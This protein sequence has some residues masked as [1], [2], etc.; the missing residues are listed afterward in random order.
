MITRSAPTALASRPRLRGVCGI[1]SGY[2]QAASLGLITP[3]VARDSRVCVYDRAGR[4]W[5]D[6]AASPPDGAQIATDLHRLLDR[7]RVPGP[8]VL[9]GQSFGGLYVRAY[10]ARYPDE[11]AGL[12]LV[13]STAAS[14]SPVIRKQASSYSIVKHVSSL[15]AT[16]SRPGVG[17]LVADADFDYLPPMYRD[18]ARATSATGKEM[19]GVIDEYGAASRS[20]AE[21]GRLHSLDAKPMFVLTAE[22][23]RRLSAAGRSRAGARCGRHHVPII[24]IPYTRFIT[25]MPCNSAVSPTSPSGS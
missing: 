15:V 20:M 12:V 24:S 1:R 16:T 22:L 5:S 3:A 17:R 6:P 14:A 25:V 10:A 4:G 23:E 11:V 13:D 2:L 21:A 18:D 8:Y 7:A 9:A 19:A